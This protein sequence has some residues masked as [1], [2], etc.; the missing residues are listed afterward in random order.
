MADT[1][2]SP[3][4]P[5]KRSLLLRAGGP[6]LVIALTALFA[7]L[8]NLPA[9]RAAAPQLA[10]ALAPVSLATS[11]P[12]ARPNVSALPTFTPVP[13]SAIAAAVN[14][15]NPQ[16][17]APAGSL[18]YS[19]ARVIGAEGNGPGE[20]NLPRA[21]A[22]GKDGRVY[23]VDQGNRRIQVFDAEGRYQFAFNQANASTA[24]VEPFGIVMTSKNELLVIDA[25]DGGIFRYDAEGRPLGAFEVASRFYKPRGFSI[26]KADNVYVTDTGGSRIIKITPNGDV[27]LEINARGKEP[28]QLDQP[29]DAIGDPSGEIWVSDCVTGRIQLF[30]AD[31]AF[32]QLFAITPSD[33]MNGSRLALG[34]DGALYVA[35]APVH[36]VLKYS[37]T[38]QLLGD[39]GSEGREP[40]QFR[41]PTNLTFAGN[42]IWVTDLAN[43]RIQKLQPK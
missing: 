22:V 30:G 15:A 21:I 24:L 19:V 36:K 27:A 42:V 38:G 28:G 7:V 5:V 18:A 20:F 43:G 16:G 37:R 29:C 17:A 33:P 2:T 35:A 4:A 34:P 10:G 12:T 13:A 39:F 11:V 3:P 25:E 26:D 41:V 6:A 40:G 1:D 8:A 14:I 32:K 31:G 23:V 9:P